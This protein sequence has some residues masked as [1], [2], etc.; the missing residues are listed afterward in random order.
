VKYYDKILPEDHNDLVDGV[1]RIRDVVKGLSD[2]LSEVK[3]E[4]EAMVQ[5][6]ERIG[7]ILGLTA[8]S[9]ELKFINPKK[10]LR[11][12]VVLWLPEKRRIVLA[13]YN[14]TDGKGE[15]YVSD[16]FGKT[17]VLKYSASGQRWRC[18]F[19]AS[20]GTLFLGSRNVG[21]SVRSVDHGESWNVITVT[22]ANIMNFTE[23]DLGAVYM[24]VHGKKV[25]KTETKGEAWTEVFDLGAIDEHL[26]GCYFD[27]YRDVFWLTTGDVEALILKYSKDFATE[28]L[29]KHIVINDVPILYIPVL[30]TENALFFGTD[31]GGWAY[32]TKATTDMDKWY[33]IVAPI[34]RDFAVRNNIWYA[35]EMGEFLT[36]W[37][38]DY[39]YFLFT[40]DYGETMRYFSLG[41]GRAINWACNAG[42]HILIVTDDIL[43]AVP[44]ET[45]RKMPIN[46]M[47]IVVFDYIVVDKTTWSLRVPVR[48][49]GNVKV[50]VK[51][52]NVDA[53][54]IPRLVYPFGM[55][56]FADTAIVTDVTE[57][58]VDWT[59]AKGCEFVCLGLYAST[60]KQMAVV[61][62]SDPINSAL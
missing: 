36:F 17:W 8:I 39:Q 9:F 34:H 55:E 3:A 6:K 4:V 1:K 27:K 11:G 30:P 62:L 19:I 28:I 15:I 13:I 58:I 52:E 46:N 25:Y 57:K 7:A 38:Y 33:H 53:P 21:Y 49:F 45:L 29:R 23:D 47:M 12:D 20:D 22:T 41:V 18:G 37:G 5:P 2:Q 44:K 24:C 48:K 51:V 16:D 60:Y 10:D 42:N 54:N 59:L 40:D 61:L 31:A 35:M 14:V 43:V 32:V 50:Y 56:Y 26:H